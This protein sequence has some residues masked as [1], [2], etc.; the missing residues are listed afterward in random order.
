MKY[1]SLFLLFLSACGEKP[2]IEPEL[3]IY[4]DRFKQEIAQPITA[5]F[6]SI[7]FGELTYPILG[8]CMR[9]IYPYSYVKIDKIS[10]DKMNENGKEELV[11]H[12]LGHCV[13]GLL[14]EDEMIQADEFQLPGSIMNSYWFGEAWFYEQFKDQYKKALKDKTLIKI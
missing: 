8:R 11:Y 12:E 5:D 1:L 2:Y 7:S 10:W 6:V 14:H 3:V 13:L 9:G 4:L